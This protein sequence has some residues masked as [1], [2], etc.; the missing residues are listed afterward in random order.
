[1]RRARLLDDL[2]R[3]RR[4][5]APLRLVGRESE[6]R[7]G[8]AGPPP[9]WPPDP[10]NAH[11]TSISPGQEAIQFH[12]RAPEPAPIAKPPSSGLSLALV[13]HLRLLT[14]AALFLATSA[15]FAK[16][17]ASASQTNLGTEKNDAAAPEPT[18]PKP[19]EAKPHEPD[20]ENGEDA[21]FGHGMQFGLR[22]GIV[23]GYKIDFRYDQSPYCKPFDHTQSVD[24]QQKICGF[25]APPASEIALSFAPLD[26]VEP[27]VFGRFG[28]SGE[29][30]SNTKPLEL[31]GVGARIY[32]MSDSRLKVFI[33]PAL[34]YELESGAGNPN[35]DLGLHPQYKK[36]MIFHVGIGPQYD[37]AKAF[38][39]FLNAGLD[40]GVLRE[41]SATL[42]VNIGV[43][44]RFP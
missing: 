2:G 11:E 21:T 8:Y 6:S 31:F 9:C 13:T 17:E 23:V 39:V 4:T 41:I 44:L 26:S 27:Y 7:I 15:S 35:W 10:V 1:M 18:A 42:L 29:S 37:F 14:G 16:D 28:F 25:G 34:A 36:D 24:D 12:A 22:A 30:Q 38:G 3:E 5:A 32:T 43:Q 33:E 20:R 19:A 40:V